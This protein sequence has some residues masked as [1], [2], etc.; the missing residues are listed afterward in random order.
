MKANMKA[1]KTYIAIPP[2]ATIK[3]QL[4][5]RGMTQKEFSERMESSTKHI[6]KLINGEVHLTN[7][8]A[9]KLERVLGVSSDFWNNLEGIYRDKL[10]RVEQEL[11]MENEIEESKSYPY[12]E[13]SNLGWVERTN[14]KEERVMRLCK[15][16]EVVNLQIVNYITIPKVAYRKL[17]QGEKGEFAL[18]AWLQK[19]KLE[20]RNIECLKFDK[21]KLS[22]S[23][24]EMRGLTEEEAPYFVPKIQSLLAESG[25]ALVVL[26]HLKGSYLQGATFM[27]GKK[28][29]IGMTLRGKEADRFWFSLFHELGH[30]I[31]GHLSQDDLTDSDEKDADEFAKELLL[32]KEAY[33]N[34]IDNGS[35]NKSIVIKFAKDQGV[36][37][38]I[39]VGRLQSD[40]VIPY[41]QLNGLK[42]IYDYNEDLIQ[43]K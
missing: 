3:E 38:G 42:M 34:L 36:H 20:S 6:S 31:L 2:G 43:T 25:V 12:N 17:G 29:V 18:N 28:V 22:K 21:Q 8:M 5:I 27:D 23:L 19:A 16:F 4:E 24:S 1:S 35:F 26:P 33:Y 9:I 7:E 41:T 30:I 40:K 15:Y 13:M 14:N 11:N 32:D 39:V 37:P 10:A